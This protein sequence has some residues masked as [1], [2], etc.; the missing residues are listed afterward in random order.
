[1]NKADKALQTKIMKDARSGHNCIR[2]KVQ[3]GTVC[4]RHYNGQRQHL[5]GKGRGIKCHPFL[6]ADF[7]NKCDRE[8]IEGAVP[9]HDYELRTQRSEEFQHWCLMT[10]IRRQENGVIG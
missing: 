10:L 4:G 8:F 7:C 2:C 9:K 1:M 6:V 5:Y 3:D